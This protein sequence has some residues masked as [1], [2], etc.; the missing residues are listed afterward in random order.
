MGERKSTLDKKR[1]RDRKR[2]GE[3]FYIFIWVLIVCGRV[4]FVFEKTILCGTFLFL[5]KKNSELIHFLF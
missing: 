3:Y 5:K 4:I 2:R 1:E